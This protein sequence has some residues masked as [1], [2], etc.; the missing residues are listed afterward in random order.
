MQP[1]VIHAH[2]YQPERLNPWTG[3]LEPEPSAAP[4]RD[5]N[6]RVHRECYRP[7]AFAR[8]FDGDRRVRNLV[9]NYER[10]SF[11]LGPTL[12]SWMERAHP[13]TYAKVLDADWRSS[14]RTGH[15]NAIAQAYNHL[16]LPLANARDVRTQIRW[17]LADFRH[18][19]SRP[20]EG[21]W[22]PEAAADRSTI[23][24]LIE[25][26]VRFTVLAPHQ[27]QRVRRP[28]GQWQDVDGAIDTSRPYRHEHSDGSGRWTS[29]FFYDGPLSQA[30]AFDPATTE[31]SVLVERLRGARRADGLVHAAVDGETFGHHHP[32]AEL[33]LAYALNV[34]GPAAGLEP[35]NYG[36]YLEQHPA[37]DEV[38]IHAEPTSWSCAHG[39]GRWERDCGCS[40]DGRPGWNQRWRTPLRAAL[41]VVRDAAIDAFETRGRQL[42]RDPWKAR[43]DYIA[44]RLRTM[45]PTAFLARHARSSLSESEQTDIWSLLESQRHA[46]VMYTSCGWFFADVSGIETVYVLR[47][48][49]RV[50]DLLEEVGVPAPRAEMLTLLSEATSN[51]P[52]A[53]TGADV[54]HSHVATAT[55]P[56]SRVAAHLTL[57]STV[58][59]PVP[60]QLE[61][62][63]YRA[64]IADLRHDSRGPISL[65]T[66]RIHLTST[67]TARTT[68]FGCAVVHLGGLDF[69]GALM[70]ADSQSEYQEAV[71]ALWQVFPTA[72]LG[73]L[74]R[75]MSDTFGTAEFGLDAALTEGRSEIA[76]HVSE[77]LDQRFGDEYRR[78]YQTHRRELEM[79]TAAG[80]QL[81][82]NL[83]AAA[84]LALS[85]EMEDRVAVALATGPLNGA[86]S[87]AAVRE[88]LE[89][90]RSNGYDLDVEPL[91][92]SLTAN[93]T[94]A[95]K[96][97]CASLDPADVAHLD[98]WLELSEL[99]GVPADITLAQEA[100]FEVATRAKAG[101]LSPAE[102]DVVAQLGDRLGLATVAWSR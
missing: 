30:L 15:G 81:P 84:E 94:E 4:D 33:G 32:F 70:R 60:S 78:L 95:A 41:D 93:V 45:T 91:R 90:A 43:D 63:G 98:R 34:A 25:A 42:L 85:T 26:G 19:F 59:A 1:V 17:G 50:L 11:N 56:P 13:A 37:V 101:R 14:V 10:L 39:V 35:T 46:M 58:R 9:N 7:N 62:A 48:A 49:A 97:A 3:V 102:A 88:I 2:F 12:L 73:K 69:T 100:A 57:L 44:V 64:S 80:Y 29:V 82:R 72:S 77:E 22:L 5:W 24:A 54:W 83:R 65:T 31:A 76:R 74:L 51:K 96:Q 79:L 92:S 36:A 38:Q 18:R 89:S 8:I 87:F 28:G 55:I 53:G 23:D 71:A 99:L 27:G 61:V 67:A 6:E 86:A 40:T 66:A 75:R 52:E 47:S 16:I 20:A 68:S 21:M